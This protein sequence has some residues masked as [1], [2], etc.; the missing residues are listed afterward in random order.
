MDTPIHNP[1]L[2][3]PY[4]MRSRINPANLQLQSPPFPY[5]PLGFSLKN[6]SSAL[7][8]TLPRASFRP[9]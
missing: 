4:P 7:V 3:P 2:L 6:S 1:P 5:S 9:G 8:L